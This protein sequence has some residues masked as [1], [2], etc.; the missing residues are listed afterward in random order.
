LVC[1][2]LS[3]PYYQE[4]AIY[5]K[6]DFRGLKSLSGKMKV[7]LYNKF[8]LDGA[9]YV[10]RLV[11][12]PTP[13]AGLRFRLV[14]SHDFESLKASH[15]GA[16]EHEANGVRLLTGLSESGFPVLQSAH[17]ILSTWLI[18]ERDLHE[19]R[20]EYRFV[21]LVAHVYGK[22]F[23]NRASTLM[24]GANIYFGSRVS[25]QSTP[26]PS[27]GPGQA[28]NTQY[29][30]NY[31]KTPQ[32]RAFLE[33]KAKVYLARV[34]LFS[35]RVDYVMNRFLPCLNT[36]AVWTQG[37]LGIT[38]A[39]QNDSH[40]DVADRLSSEDEAAKLALARKTCAGI[41]SVYTEAV[42]AYLEKSAEMIGLGY[43]TTCAYQHVYHPAAPKA[44]ILVFQYFI[45]TGLG[46]CCRIEDR[47]GHDFK[48][49]AFEHCTSLSVVLQDGLVHWVNDGCVQV[50]AWGG[51][52]S[53]KKS[54]ANERRKKRSRP[55]EKKT[56]E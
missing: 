8:I 34:K 49:F 45:M 41:V 43:P 37:I 52:E 54:G 27:E 35:A 21:E 55:A 39:F 26:S 17:P 28:S 6:A 16:V 33:K 56:E 51:W 36:C 40:V 50:V 22:G 47:V 14:S 11:C 44:L 31:Y 25:D 1:F 30:R 3:L 15:L 10:V 53:S 38:Y 19:Q 18:E 20:I 23:G 2:S 5:K 4:F 13:G 48:A 46:S 32:L 12:F 7:E 24:M 29:F 42:L 9:Y